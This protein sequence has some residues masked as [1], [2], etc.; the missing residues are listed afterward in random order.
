M[1]FKPHFQSAI[2]EERGNAHEEIT[3]SYTKGMSPR[4]SSIH[5][6]QPAGSLNSMDL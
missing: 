4:V 1:Y 5:G 2:T 6:G 3:R